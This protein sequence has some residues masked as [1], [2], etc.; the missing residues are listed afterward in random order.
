MVMRILQN[1]V[2]MKEASNKDKSRDN[3]LED[4]SFFQPE[5]A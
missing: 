1:C 3:D 4:A 5:P 2:T